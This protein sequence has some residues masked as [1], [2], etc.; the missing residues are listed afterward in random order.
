MVAPNWTIK[1]SSNMRMN[2]PWYS[3]ITNCYFLKHELLCDAQNNV[4]EL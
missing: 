2:K 4:G 1:L 3:H